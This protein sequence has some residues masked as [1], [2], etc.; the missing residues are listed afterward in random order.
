MSG[1]KFSFT[2]GLTNAIITLIFYIVV[3][4]L[5]FRVLEG[6]VPGL[7]L[8]D[9]RTIGITTTGAFIAAMSFCRGAFPKHSAIWALAGIGSSLF[10]A[11]YTYILLGTPATLS[12]SAGGQPIIFTFDIGLLALLMA[13]VMALNSLNN[14]IELSN[15]R[16]R[17]TE[18]E[19]VA[20][21]KIAV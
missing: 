3:P 20:K 7:S 4:D 9:A 17:K 14:L 18:T 1:S 19:R 12:T 15:A 11:V 13:A 2:H 8:G 10:A 21:T 5:V 16:R 6:Y